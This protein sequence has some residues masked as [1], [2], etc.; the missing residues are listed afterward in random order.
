MKA[1]VGMGL[2]VESRDLVALSLVVGCFVLVLA[3]RASWEQVISVL[4]LV[5]GYYF[6]YGIGYSRGVSK[7]TKE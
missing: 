4:M 6:G 3:G 7:S 1:V 5:A 2:R